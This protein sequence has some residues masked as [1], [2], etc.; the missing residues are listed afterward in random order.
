M[1]YSP[2]ASGAATT[3]APATVLVIEKVETIHVVHAEQESSDRFINDR[4]T[5]NIR[6]EADLVDQLF[7]STEWRLAR[8]LLLV[9]W[10]GEDNQPQRF[11]PKVS[12]ETLADT[13]GTTRSRV[14][15]FMNKFNKLGVIKY[16]GGLRID[17][18]LLNVT[19]H[20]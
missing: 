1:H 7:N 20:E 14:N 6:I 5:R 4:L 12:Q 19:L 3:P 11:L 13:I 10:Y 15:H 17:E 2:F 8:A 18:S 9:A 16:N